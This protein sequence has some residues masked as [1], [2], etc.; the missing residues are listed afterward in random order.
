MA[1][2]LLAFLFGLLFYAL[3]SG[4]VAM[5]LAGV[6]S[7]LWWL[8]LLPPALCHGLAGFIAMTSAAGRRLRH[9]RT[10]LLSALVAATTTLLTLALAIAAA[11]AVPLS[12]PHDSAVAV[13]LISLLAGAAGLLLAVWLSQSSLARLRMAPPSEK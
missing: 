1:F 12:L 8:A 9:P 3:A 7:A 11:V 5:S 13:V 10:L 6:A 2:P 4:L